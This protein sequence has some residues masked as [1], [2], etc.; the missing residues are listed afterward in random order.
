VLILHVMLVLSTLAVLGVA[1]GCYR[2]ICR[3]LHMTPAQPP[4]EIAPKA[5]VEADS[6]RD[7]R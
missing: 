3:H 4:E 1:Y 6:G 2:H 5:G 7:R